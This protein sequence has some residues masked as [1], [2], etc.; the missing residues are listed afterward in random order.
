MTLSASFCAEKH[1]AEETGWDKG[2]KGVMGKR[3]KCRFHDTIHKKHKLFIQIFMQDFTEH[4]SLCTDG[5]TT[6][7]HLALLSGQAS[8]ESWCCPSVCVTGFGLFLSSVKRKKN[9]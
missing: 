6:Q 3:R 9:L 2:L 1:K 7:A 8:I 5:L 4:I